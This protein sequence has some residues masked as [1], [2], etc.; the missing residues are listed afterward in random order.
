MISFPGCFSTEL[1]QNL[2]IP[3]GLYPISSYGVLRIRS[4]GVRYFP[5]A[6]RYHMVILL[7]PCLSTELLQN[8][9]IKGGLYLKPSTVCS[10]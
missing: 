9:L 1:L 4:H 3:C 7:P 5:G 10:G 6:F 8:L 2:L